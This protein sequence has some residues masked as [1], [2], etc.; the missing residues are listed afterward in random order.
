[1]TEKYAEQL[2]QDGVSQEHIDTYVKQAEKN[3]T[4]K[5]ATDTH[6]ASVVEEMNQEA[7][8]TVEENV[9]TNIQ[10]PTELTDTI[11]KL[12]TGA[13]SKL[14]T[15]DTLS[16]A[17]V[18]ALYKSTVDQYAETLKSDGFTE[19]QVK[20]YLD[21]AM[22]TTEVE[23]QKNAI[24][25]LQEEMGFGNALSD[26]SEGGIIDLTLTTLTDNYVEGSDKI[27]NEN[28]EL[29]ANI[30]YKTGEFS[31]FYKTDNFARINQFAT[32]QLH[33]TS[34][35]GRLKHNSNT[36]GKNPGDHAGHIIADQ[37]G[38]SPELDNLVSQ[39]SDIN[40]SQYKK[41]EYQWAKALK[42]NQIVKIDIKIKYEKNNK[43]PSVFVIYYEIDG[44][45]F[46]VILNN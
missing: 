4:S 29:N 43:R 7:R 1:M 44:K 24:V 20:N 30:H 15:L 41:I 22:K 3:A 26:E 16:D 28:G 38:G 2:K 37:F 18:N 12:K 11:G 19:A 9:Q 46:K 35:T 42:N 32:E 34:R 39:A 23:N 10:T 21:E 8:S 40:L 36:P 5:E 14:K 31:Y 25:K 27:F 6:T 17:E 45:P 13:V 33:N